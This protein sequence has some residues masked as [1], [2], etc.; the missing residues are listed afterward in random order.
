M[1]ILTPFIPTF[2]ASKATALDP[3]MIA[4]ANACRL[5]IRP[6]GKGRDIVRDIIPS[7]LTSINYKKS[8]SSIRLKPELFP[9]I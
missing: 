2:A 1:S 5:E 9:G 4:N 7:F 8:Q 6:A 3:V